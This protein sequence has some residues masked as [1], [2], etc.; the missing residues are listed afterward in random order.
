MKELTFLVYTQHQNFARVNFYF[1]CLTLFV[2]ARHHGNEICWFWHLQQM[3]ALNQNNKCSQHPHDTLTLSWLALT[4]YPLSVI[5]YNY[6]L[7]VKALQ[8]PECIVVHIFLHCM[9]LLFAGLFSK[10]NYNEGQYCISE[11]WS[12]LGVNQNAKLVFVKVLN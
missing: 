9:H 11:L 1:I 6:T 4:L 7:T 2:K 12:E 10:I 8:F 3:A 5:S